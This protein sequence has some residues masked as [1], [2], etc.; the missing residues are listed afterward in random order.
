MG[1]RR[2][3]ALVVGVV[4]L[5]GLPNAPARAETAEEARAEAR[6]VAAR[7][8]AMQPR[9][10]KALAAYDRALGRLA[11]GVTRSLS[12]EQAADQ[13]VALEAEHRD[14]ETD[15]VRAI[16]MTGGAAALY[17]SVL[18]AG[19]PVDAMARVVYVQRL[20]AVG[21]AALNASST[22]TADLQ[23]R[24]DR[25]QAAAET[26]TTTASEVQQ[27]YV[28]LD[29]VI[30]ELTAELAALSERASDLQQAQ[31]LLAQVAAL[32][33]AVDA[34]G[35]ARVST[36]RASAIPAAFRAL[37]VAAARTCRGMSWT[38]LAAVGQV[39]SG[40][41][42]NTN[43]SYAG[44]QGPMQFMPATFEAYAVDG[45]GDGDRDIRDPADSVFS[46][47]HYL[48]A[49]GAGRGGHALERAVWHYNHADWYVALVL[50]LAGQYAERD[51]A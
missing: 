16:Y 1:P 23:D 51:G 7:M 36:A 8:D 2:V 19:G 47:A 21:A 18:D 49:N 34:T 46:A 15:R 25:L 24:A 11:V 35:A 12:A 27:R 3:T 28:E 38:L 10:E 4:L 5:A 30:D 32:N 33:A 13:A 43:T 48:C 9:V 22:T 40:H 42:A 14:A 45:D 6:A 26:R 50:K 31:D 17:A 44:A 29:A 20:V 37:Y 39:E 41:G